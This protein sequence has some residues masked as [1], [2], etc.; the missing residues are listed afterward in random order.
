MLCCFL[1]SIVVGF[2]QK[3][4][5]SK[6]K[7]LE[8]K[9]KDLLA[10]ITETK[11]AMA[12]ARKKESS[13]LS[14]LK[15]ISAQ[16][17]TRDRVIGNIE[18]QIFELDVEIAESNTVIDTLNAQIVRLKL[19][20]GKYMLA[21]YKNTNDLQELI[22]IFNAEGFNSAYKRIN[23]LDKL[24]VYRKLQSKLIGNTQALITTEVKSMQSIKTEKRELAGIKEVEKKE[25]VLDKVEQNKVLTQLQTKGKQLQIQLG[26]TERAY[27]KLNK[28]IED[29]IAKEIEDA[30][31]REANRKKSE[32][33]KT[34]AKSPNIGLSPEAIKLSATFTENRGSLPWPVDNGYV[35]E[36]FGEHK[37]PTLSGVKTKNNGAN[38]TCREGSVVK[39]IFGGTVKAIFSVP[40]LELVVLINHGEYYS[41]YANMEKTSVKIGQNIVVGQNIGV[42]FTSPTDK[43]TEL[44]F[45]L[46]KL[47]QSQDPE[48]WLKN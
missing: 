35:S 5:T 33:G 7:E 3:A 29:L 15:I 4:S 41:V 40:G 48:S 36:G 14:E 2:S 19:D 42:V 37:H 9:R 23:Y 11:V 12:V 6:R 8:T 1:L 22:F 13:K 45:E 10:R 32:S 46:Y 30:R 20:F 16:I 43:K 26:E 31:L 34:N 17:K 38:I 25:L 39:S 18:Q 21:I 47:K 44:H 28:A 27:R 24:A